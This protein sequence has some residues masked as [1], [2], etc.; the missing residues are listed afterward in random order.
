MIIINIRLMKIRIKYAFMHSE[1][2]T[3]G[4]SFVSTIQWHKCFFKR[5]NKNEIFVTKV[6]YQ[7]HKIK[8]QNDLHFSI[9]R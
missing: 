5:I 6:F 9:F 3:K 8:Y 1:H 2:I 4:S 7:R